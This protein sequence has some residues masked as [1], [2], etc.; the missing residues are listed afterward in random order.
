M[1][2]F[3]YLVSYR[4]RVVL[5]C[6]MFATLTWCG[7]HYRLDDALIYA[8]YV[9]HAYQSRGLYFNDGERV[10]AL[11][12]ILDTWLQLGLTYVLHGRVLLAQA[13]LGGAFLFGALLMA[14]AVVPLAGVLLAAGSY[15]YFLTGM[16]TPIFVFCLAL[17]VWAYTAGKYNWLPLLCVL[18]CLAR[19]EGGALLLVITLQ[20]WRQRRFPPLVSFV[21]ALLLIAV[22]LLCNLH[23][24]GSPLPQSAS[25]KIG[26]GMS[27]LWGRW[28]T[29]F[30]RFPS[31]MLLPLGGCWVFAVILTI[32]AWFGS[33]APNMATRNQ[34]VIP[35]IVLLG[36]FYVLCNIPAYRWYYA[37][38]IYFFYIYAARLIPA[39]KNFQVS[40]LIVTVCMALFS[41]WDLW[42]NGIEE[43]PYARAGDW[44]NEHTPPDARIAAIETGTIGWHCDRYLIDV[45]GLTTPANARYTANGDISSWIKERPDYIVVHFDGRFRWEKVALASPDYEFL[46]VRF[47]SVG[48]LRR[49]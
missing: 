15:F 35:F 11:T 8:R 42:H 44:L 34:L 13:I 49:K 7:R 18:C 30:L 20:L 9:L 29:A 48:L 5:I 10:N 23:F 2:P 26:Q 46:P 41:S 43:E 4:L 17:T 12:S 31:D 24:Y 38:F 14:E 19:L 32:L 1:S 16:E 21:P 37:P 25:A 39:K 28:P 27:G 6:V 47:N 3:P 45:V 40:V 33:R 36:S 22:Y